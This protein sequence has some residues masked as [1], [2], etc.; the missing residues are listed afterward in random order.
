MSDRENDGPTGNP[1]LNR[2][3]ERQWEDYQRRRALGEEDPGKHTRDH[4][5]YTA[6]FT[7]DWHPILVSLVILGTIVFG[8]FCLLVWVPV[9]FR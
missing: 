6:W 5:R 4:S 1:R 9:A 7:F 2:R 3:L 8:A